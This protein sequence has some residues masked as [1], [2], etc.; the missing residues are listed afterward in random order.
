MSRRF[1]TGLSIDF[2]RVQQ[3]FDR[4]AIYW[5]VTFVLAFLVIGCITLKNF[6]LTWDEGL[7]NLFFGERY[8]RYFSSF[9][10]VFLDFK[11]DLPVLRQHTL[12][13]FLSPFHQVPNEFPPVADT[14]SAATMY[15]F[16]YTLGWLNPIDGF[17]LFTVLFASLFLGILYAFAA[18]RLGKFAAWMAVLFLAA[19][20]RFWADMH[21]NVKDVPETIF[22]GLVIFSFLAWYEKPAIWRALLT[23]LLWGLALGVK[24]NAIFLPLIL[25]GGVIPWTFRKAVWLK[26]F[27]Q[28]GMRIPTVLGHGLLAGIAALAVYFTSWPYLYAH[29]LNNLKTYWHYI[30]TQGGRTGGPGWSIDPLRQVLTTMPEVMLLALATGL[31]LAAIRVFRTESE[32]R[33][34]TPNPPDPTILRVLLLWLVFPILRVSLPGAVNFDGI[35]HFLEFVPAAALLAGYGAAQAVRL[36][37]RIAPRFPTIAARALPMILL[38][39]NMVQINLSFYPFL[40]LY[41]NALTG[42]L[43]GARQGWLGMEAGDYWASSYRQGMEWLSQ[44][45]PAGSVVHAMSAGW[46]VDISAPVFLR[47]DI[48]VMPVE[49]LPDFSV[50]DRSEKPVYLMFALRGGDLLDELAYCQKRKAPVYQIVVDNAPILQIF[51]FGGVKQ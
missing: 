6:G 50:L 46:I 30:F 44:N 23:G 16:S 21:F 27:G 34:D 29:P 51:K 35:R 32:N 37:Q 47:P 20:P 22:F 15:L 9:K 5:V 38:V 19:F 45:A 31:I 3:W 25:A 28:R 42:G 13:L 43:S 41:Y 7:G 17:H 10:E 36:L 12:N 40:H 24:A 26:A 33:V 8:L 14:L 11:A 4:T 48:Q 1:P 39:A 18:P 49:H 2:E